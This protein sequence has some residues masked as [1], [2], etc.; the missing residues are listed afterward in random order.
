MSAPDPTDLVQ[1]GIVAE[2]ICNREFGASPDRWE[3]TFA[4]AT[5]DQETY[6]AATVGRLA[7]TAQAVLA[8]LR[9]AGP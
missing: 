7:R 9:D 6:A 3:R 1:I 8:A 4:R 2:V 5:L